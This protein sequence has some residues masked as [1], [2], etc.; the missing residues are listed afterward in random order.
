M[1]TWFS[2]EINYEGFAAAHTRDLRKF[3]VVCRGMSAKFSRRQD[4]R[5]GC[6]DEK[7]LI[8]IKVHFFVLFRVFF[9]PSYFPVSSCHV[10][11]QRYQPAWQSKKKVLIAFLRSSGSWEKSHSVFK[12]PAR[13]RALTVC[14]PW[15]LLLEYFFAKDARCGSQYWQWNIAESRSRWSNC[16]VVTLKIFRHLTCVTHFISAREHFF[17]PWVCLQASIQT[18]KKICSSL[19][20]WNKTWEIAVN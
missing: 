16:S 18:Q 10:D 7:V 1:M 9:S 8:I 14:A 13:I 20:S 6:G 11:R 15:I 17:A 12:R 5:G 2:S 3:L 4:A 19:N